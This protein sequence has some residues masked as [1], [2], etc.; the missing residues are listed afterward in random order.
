MGR[1]RLRWR[2]VYSL[3]GAAILLQ[4]TTC[5]LSDTQTQQQFASQFLLPQLAT[6]FSDLVFF[7]LDNA[8]VHITT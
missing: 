6:A 8:L 7:V 4:T 3:A 1:M 5:T 2:W